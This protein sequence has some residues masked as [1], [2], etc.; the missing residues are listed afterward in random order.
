MPGNQQINVKTDEYIN[1]LSSI[2][3]KYD[4]EGKRL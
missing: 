2:N 3:K 4:T 1:D